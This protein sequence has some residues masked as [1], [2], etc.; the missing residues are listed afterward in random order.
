[1]DTS[2]RLS[3][4]EIENAVVDQLRGLLRSPE[5][6]VRTWRATRKSISD[7]KEADVRQALE[8]LDPLWDEL[9]PAEQARVVHL[10]VERVD[11]SP[12]GVDIRLRTEGMADLVTDLRAI[13]QSPSPCE[14][15]DRNIVDATVP[16]PAT[17]SPASSSAQPSFPAAGSP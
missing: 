1:M 3:A 15:R 10:L 16:S 6:I 7:I 11:V 13:R 14:R 5:I 2:Q 17:T 8:R 12:D 4:G 9:F